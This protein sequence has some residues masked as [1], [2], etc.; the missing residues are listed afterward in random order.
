MSAVSVKNLTKKFGDF[1]VLTIL[2]IMA[3]GPEIDSELDSGLLTFV[4]RRERFNGTGRRMR[5]AVYESSTIEELL[6]LE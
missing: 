6:K 4:R 2:T 1:T 3:I 5:V